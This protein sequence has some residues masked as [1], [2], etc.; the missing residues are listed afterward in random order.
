MWFV[1]LVL[2]HYPHCY[3]CDRLRAEPPFQQSLSLVQEKS[4]VEI[5]DFGYWTMRKSGNVLH[6]A[7]RVLHNM[8]TST[9][10][11]SSLLFLALPCSSLLFL[12][13]P[14]SSL[15]FLTLPKAHIAFLLNDKIKEWVILNPY[16]DTKYLQSHILQRAKMVIKYLPRAKF[17]W[18]KFEIPNSYIEGKIWTQGC[19]SMITL[20][21]KCCKLVVGITGKGKLI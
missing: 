4:V 16:R 13:L 21:C 10:F 20:S 7:P 3:H 18:V 11:C 14:C 6:F 17:W 8:L 12:A 19:Y 15:L 1:W 9:F 2:L 5:N